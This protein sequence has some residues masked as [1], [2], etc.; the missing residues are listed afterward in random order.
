MTSGYLDIW[1]KYTAVEGDF[2]LKKA[3]S[4]GIILIDRKNISRDQNGLMVY[5]ENLTAEQRAIVSEG[6]YLLVSEDV[7]DYLADDK[8]TWEEYK[9]LHF[10]QKAI[11]SPKNKSKPFR[12]KRIDKSGS[13]IIEAAGLETLPEGY[14]SYSIYGDMQQILRR[15]NAR[16]LIENGES[17]LP[18]L[19]L[20]IE[21]KKPDAPIQ[22]VQA[23]RIE[24]ISR[25]VREKIFAYEPRPKQRDAIDI[26]LNTP[27]IAI[28]QG[29]P[30][31][32]KTTVITAIIERLNELSD[33]RKD[34]RGQVLITS[35]QHDAVRNVIYRLSV[36]SLP[37]VKFGKQ[38]EDDTSQDQ[39]IEKWCQDLIQ[40][41]KQ[42]NPAIQ[43]T[44]AQRE[45]ERL[46]N[47]Y[48]ASPNDEN[49]LAFLECAR[50]LNYNNSLNDEIEAIIDEIK[51]VEHS[52]ESRLIEKIRRLRCT[53]LGFMDDG[54]DTADD[55][56]AEL[57]EILDSKSE[58]NK[59]ILDVLQDA[60]DSIDGID[61]NLLASLQSV[62]QE[63]L[64]KC[65]S[66]PMYKIEQPRPEITE[67]Y[68]KIVTSLSKPANEEEEILFT[69]LNE[70]ENNSVDVE[71]MIY[72]H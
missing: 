48:L 66:R 63:L 69:L 14:I 55:L 32:G 8:M 3:R 70:L 38:G 31:T 21:G 65:I 36:N 30:G 34:N 22:V 13:W 44:I 35:F 39:I 60:A 27:D 53:K 16:K 18:S 19:G 20:V 25:H 29:P 72:V 40:R 6:D 28:I 5:P 47:S 45:F 24:P 17:A 52:K 51:T 59:R 46:H 7:P 1:D 26:A 37:T 61:D 2:I 56:L 12:I 11:S 67:L 54:C 43:Q 4:I 15:E 33:K 9:N 10:S 62:K 41:L 49:A 42:R 71:R 58:S 23:K 57:E 64:S 50:R 68:S